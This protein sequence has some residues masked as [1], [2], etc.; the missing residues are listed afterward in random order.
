MWLGFFIV[1]INDPRPVTRGVWN[2][3][4]IAYAVSLDG[5][6]GGLKLGEGKNLEL[7]VP[8]PAKLRRVRQAATLHL[9][10]VG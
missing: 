5:A 2:G 7:V 3:Y 1:K 4:R 9:G 6:L 8:T 10:C